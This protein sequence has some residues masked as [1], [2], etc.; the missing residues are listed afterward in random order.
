MVFRSGKQ[1]PLRSWDMSSWIYCEVVIR[2]SQM[3]STFG[4]RNCSADN[5]AW[6]YLDPRCWSPLAPCNKCEHFLPRQRWPTV[7]LHA[8]MVHYIMTL[9][10]NYTLQW[11]RGCRSNDL[12][13][14]QLQWRIGAS[15][16]CISRWGYQG[17]IQPECILKLMRASNVHINQHECKRRV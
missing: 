17:Q 7:V 5:C 3:Q 11:P 16:K 4:L 13:W 6:A 15:S 10:H 9:S 14:K 8:V 12:L 1:R 2:E